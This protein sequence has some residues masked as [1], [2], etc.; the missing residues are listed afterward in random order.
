MFLTA[1]ILLNG[2]PL[3]SSMGSHLQPNWSPS[4]STG[5]PSPA[6]RGAPLQ[7]NGEPLSSSMESPSPAQREAPLQ[8]NGEP[9]PAQREASPAQREPLSISPR[10]GENGIA[11]GLAFGWRLTPLVLVVVRL[12][13]L[14]LLGVLGRLALPA[15][16]GILDVLDILGGGISRLTRRLTPSHWRR[17]YPLPTG[18]SWR[19]AFLPFYLFTFLP[20]YFFT[21]KHSYQLPAPQHGR[22]EQHNPSPLR[23]RQWHRA[24]HLSS[25]GHDDPLSGKHKGEH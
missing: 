8:L 17:P 1:P 5:S 6:Q 12:A 14:T 25:E 22:G 19:G 24:E 9:S 11:W 3:S 23:E 10:R 16:L 7:L 21:F 2:E 4:S 20:F 13:E 18:E 15:L